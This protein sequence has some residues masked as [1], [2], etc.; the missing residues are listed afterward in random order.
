MEILIALLFALGLITVIGHGIWVLLAMIFR[1]VFSEPKPQTIAIADVTGARKQ[2]EERCAECGAVLQASDKFCAVCGQARA[3]AGPVADLATTARQLDKFLNEGKLDAETHNRVMEVVKEER[4]R[5]I[6]PVRRDTTVTP[7]EAEPPPVAPAP[8][9]A[10]TQQAPPA[11]VEQKV[12]AVEREGGGLS[13]AASDA[14]PASPGVKQPRRSFTE[15]LE[16]FMEESSI[17]WGELIGGLLIIGCSIALVVSLWSEI[18]S[19]PFLKFSVFI[20]VTSALFGLG[21]YSAHRWKLPTTSRGV[22]IISTLLAPLNFLAMTAFSHEAVPASLPVV[23]AELFSLALFLFLVYQAARVF[24]PGAPWMTAL[25]TM[26][27]SFALLMARHSANYPSGAQAGW[28]RVG[29]LGFAPLLCYWISCGAILRDHAGRDESD[30]DENDDSDADQIFAHLGISSFATL[31]PLGLLF[32]KPGYLSQ[33]LRQFAPL[34]SLFGIPAIATGIALL[35]GPARLDEK[36][37]GKTQTAA[38]SIT[39][40][41]SLISLAA[42]IF[43]WPNVIA[44]TITALINCAVCLAIALASS[45]QAL[46]YDLRLAHIGAIGHLSLAVLTVANLLSRNVLSWSED[47]PR[48]AVSFVSITS[49]VALA[50]LFTLFAI[51]S[52]WWRK[53]DGKIESRIYGIGSVAVGAFS[54]LLI[55]AHGFGRAG[56]PHHAALGYAFYAL[57]AFVIAWRREEV[58]P[59]WIGNA[60]LLLTIVQALAFKFGAE[61]ATHH[62]VRLSL[63]VF[64]NVVTVAAV[65]VSFKSERARKPF[66][67]PLT[68]SALAASLAVA[69]FLIFEGWMTTAQISARMLWLAAIWLVIACLRGWPMLFAA[70]QLALAS[71]VLFGTADLFGHRWPQSFVGDLTTMQAQAVALAMLSL[72]WIAARLAFRR[73]G[74]TEEIAELRNGGNEAESRFFNLGV[75]AKLFY[76]GWPG[77]DRVVTLLL[78]VFLAGLSLYG[79]HVGMIEGLHLWSPFSTE[80]RNLTATAAGAGSWLLL[81]VLS[82]V[83]IAGLWE[84]FEKR[85]ALAMLILLACACLL[86]AGRWQ[87]AGLTPAVYRWSSAIAFAAVSSL[88][89]LRARVAQSLRQFGWRRFD[90][91]SSGTAALLR[92][93]SLALFVAPVLVL[94]LFSFLTAA[95]TPD[96]THSVAAHAGTVAALIGPVL[97]MAISFVALAARE[98]SAGYACAAGLLANL[99]VTLGYLLAVFL[100]KSGPDRTDIYTVAQLN[101]ITT[102]I[103][104][105]VWIASNRHWAWPRSESF[106]KTQTGAALVLTLYL[107]AIAAS[108]LFSDPWTNN[109]LA[110]AFGGVMGWLAVLPPMLAFAQIRGIRPD[111]LRV[112]QFAVCLLA[113]GSLLVCVVSRLADDYWITYHAL[114]MM[115]NAAAWL[116]LAIRWFALNTAG[117]GQSEESRDPVSRLAEA[118]LRIG[119]QRP[120]EKWIAALACATVAMILR[121]AASPGEPW[122]AIGFSISVCLLFAGL[123]VMSRGRGYIYLAAAALNYAAT[124]FYFWLD[125]ELF[126]LSRG[127]LELLGLLAVNTIVLALPAIAWLAID[128]K[129]LRRNAAEKS[130][131]RITPFHRVAARISLGLLSLIL[132]FQWLLRVE[133]SEQSTISV[134]S[135]WLALASV[136][137]LLAACLWDKDSEYALRGLYGV[138]LIAIGMILV[139]LNLSREA[140]LVAVVIALSLFALAVSILLRGREQL[141]SLATRLRIPLSNDEPA[142]FSSW[143]ITANGALGA[144]VYALTFLIVFS[145]DSLSQRLISATV[146]IAI[147]ISMALLAGTFKNQGLITK[148]AGSIRI[149]GENVDGSEGNEVARA[150]WNQNLITVC[151]WLAM[152]SAVLWGW[153]WLSP[154]ASLQVINRAVI[155]MVIAEAVLIGYRFII[156]RNLANENEWRRG[157]KA[158]LPIVTAI[159][160]AALAI[161]LAA[162][163]SNYISF[164]DAMMPWPVIIAV[165]VALISLFCA[166]VAFA[167]SPGRDPFN[168]SE[169]GRMNYVYDAEALTVVTLLHARLTL[170]WLFGGFF[171]TWWP[172]VV[173]LLA[174]TGVGLGELFRNRGKLVLAEP[175]E[176]TGILLPLLPVIGFWVVASEVSYSGLLFLV[177]LFYGV[178]SVMR[179]SFTFGILAVFAGNGGLWKLLNGVEGYGFYQHP[180]LWLIPVSLSVLAAARINRDRLTQEQMTVIRYATLMMIYV[181]STSDIFING[182]SESPWLTMALAVLSVMGV[183]AGLMLRVRAFLFLGTA[184]LLLSVLTMIWTASVNLN[185]GWLWSVTGIAFGA[186]IIFIF[187]LFER[188]RHEM[189][190]LVEQLKQWQA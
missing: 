178:L 16:T 8:V 181:S 164:R 175:L 20:G 66:A 160:L 166:C 138:G 134:L 65:I 174:F 93:S 135:G 154:I 163:V 188:K 120:L 159:G 142:R 68:S 139:S 104:S 97:L 51:A 23:G 15:M 60:L 38:T 190:K 117:K 136:T 55:T 71:S 10:V 176:R 180:Q 114:M 145:L 78:L 126:G 173:M 124:R 165:F 31:L 5:L 100:A 98:R 3:S 184:F 96:V 123:S 53:K 102:S 92:A 185:W 42:L 34:V 32:I 50:L 54:V 101:I 187:A 56:D 169:R 62:P 77:V 161:A 67:G 105:L 44:V 12:F 28:L 49:G 146:S 40:I 18:T 172:L 177:G 26:G 22:L 99:S 48:L 115:L 155:V 127:D 64:A 128:L 13:E 151:I 179:R 33:T 110:N 119:D 84:R 27:P 24:A 182:V 7:R 63:L 19:R 137:A 43:A 21:F 109:A 147:P 41:G 70:V 9:E 121:G 111:R 171:L 91:R 153:A 158:Q 52:E 170:P 144:A 37:S 183:I 140:L 89:V 122:W 113:F 133:G 72:I 162:E 125:L 46:R 116:M 112:E 156:S 150:V 131:S 132:L 45:R 157:V 47:S 103:C 149:V 107:L 186:L 143:L 11:F 129:L 82:L 76:P 189:L 106:L 30:D 94:T 69:P 130:T 57:A 6:A 152:L 17:R 61:L 168:L 167:L 36:Q 73:F 80:S 141:R 29:L 87:D 85:A 35:Q 79:V 90:E 86:I 148:V 4:E 83:F 108:G 25:A 1:A 95:S 88:I 118:V 2:H 39:I 59:S 75:V 81:L 74:A 58:V 14:T